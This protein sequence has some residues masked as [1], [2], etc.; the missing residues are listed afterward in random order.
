MTSDHLLSALSIATLFN[1]HLQAIRI[2]A[3]QLLTA[4]VLGLSSVKEG[5]ADYN[6]I[7]VALCIGGSAP[8]TDIF[9]F[10]LFGKNYKPTCDYVIKIHSQKSESQS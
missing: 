4:A 3:A 10:P 2:W 8:I 9:Y 6:I 1:L 5:G 7:A